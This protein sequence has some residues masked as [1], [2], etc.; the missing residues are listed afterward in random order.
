[1]VWAMPPSPADD[2]NPTCIVQSAIAAAKGRGLCGTF[3]ALYIFVHLMF[4]FCLCRLS[5]LVPCSISL[6]FFSLK[7][8]LL[9]VG[10]GLFFCSTLK[11]QF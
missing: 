9:L 4:G 5:A 8:S 7:F 10:V 3:C 11:L 2:N 6:F 1:M